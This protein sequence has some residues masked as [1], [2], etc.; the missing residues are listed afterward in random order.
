MHPN[1]HCSTIC[2]SQDM[3]ATKMSINRGMDKEDVIYIYH[4]ILLSHKKKMPFAGTWMDVEISIL[5]EVSQM[6]KYKHHVKS[7]LCGT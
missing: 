2:N 4:K 6:E 1:G 5:R 3:G 7:L